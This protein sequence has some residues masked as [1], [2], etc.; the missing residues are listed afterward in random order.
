[1]QRQAQRW[2]SCPL[3]EGPSKADYSGFVVTRAAPEANNNER[4]YG[5]GVGLVSRGTDHIISPVEVGSACNH[6]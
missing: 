2:S 5:E 3:E 6:F 4:E 1:V